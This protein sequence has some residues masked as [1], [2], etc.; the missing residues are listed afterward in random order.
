MRDRSSGLVTDSGSFGQKLN[1]S[2]TF[3]KLWLREGELDSD[4]EEVVREAERVPSNHDVYRTFR[5]GRR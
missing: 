4:L 3:E 1:V 5:R 2:P